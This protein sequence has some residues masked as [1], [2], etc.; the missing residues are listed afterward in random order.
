MPAPARTSL[1]E[2]V[3]AGRDLV[4]T[5]GVDG[6]TMGA[7]AAAVGVKAP[8]LYKHVSSRADLV[9]LIAEAVVAELG[10]SLESSVHGTDAELDLASLAQAFR[11]FAHSRPQ[12]YRLVFSPL[13]EE[14]RPG[15]DALAAAS[16]PVLRTVQALAG[17][18]H[19]LDGA[20]LVTAWAHG[21]MTME[22]AGAFRLDGDLDRAFS[23]GIER[24][25]ASLSVLRDGRSE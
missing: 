11:A 22:L 20:R 13:P 25:A 12:A 23:F 10:V 17:P 3:A 15:R 6:L 2:I 21:F 5:E 14:W 24:L 7:V 8:S 16:E 9:R 4:D 18:E 1:D 19:A